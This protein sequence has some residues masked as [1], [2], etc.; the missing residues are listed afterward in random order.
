MDD[1]PADEDQGITAYHGSPHEFDQFD[2]SKIGTGEGAQSYGHG[3]Y[4]A[5]AE[6]VATGYRD[7]LSQGTYKTGSG[8]IFDP[9]YNL[10]HMNI[11]VA[12]YKNIDN[13]IDRAHELLE[14]QPENAGKINRDLEKLYTAKAQSAEPNKG[15]MYEVRINAHPDHFIDWDKPLDE[16][17]YV[18]QK[19]IEAGALT[20]KGDL[21][22]M[23]NET[24]RGGGEMYERLTSP[25]ADRLTG[26]AGQK[27]ASD[28]LHG[29]GI[30]GIKYLDQGSRGAGEGSR[31]YVVFDDKLV[32]TK[33]RYERG[34]RVGYA[35]GSLV[36]HA[37]NVL[38]KA[39]A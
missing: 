34:G 24:P 7:K 12:A 27:Y 17:P 5:E 23:Y 30:K 20:P 28:F 39:H 32:T 36:N 18:K 29:I 6:P 9:F 25:L 35:D 8:S 21:S 15:H 10:E 14:T 33:R 26:G 13:A 38:R 4:F 3:L 1:V 19:L 37:L 16:Q 2:M 11:R 22:F 31:N